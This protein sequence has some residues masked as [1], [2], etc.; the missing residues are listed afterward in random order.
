MWVRDE[1]FV[2]LIHIILEQQVSLASAKAAFDRLAAS[3]SPLTP[4]GFLAL[5]DA[6][7]KAIGFSRQKAGY[8]RHLAE[9]IA[10]GR[11]DPESLRELD[12]DTARAAL[13]RLKG[14]GPWSADIYLLMVLRRPDVWPAGDL[15]LAQAAQKVKGLSSCPSPSELER[16]AA[17]WRPW[18][19]VAARLLWH[20]Y[21]SGAKTEFV[22]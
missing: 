8:G 12:D 21:L 11:F 6:A 3:V 18:R 10:T 9:E 14:I 15:A 13:V 22:P 4:A 2:T 5:D 19:A 16:L 20:L 1:G 7:L 17:P